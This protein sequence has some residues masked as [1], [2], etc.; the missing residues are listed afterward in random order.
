MNKEEYINQLNAHGITMSMYYE[1][2]KDKN[3]KVRITL[4]EYQIKAQKKFLTIQASPRGQ[5]KINIYNQ[6]VQLYLDK[7]FKVTR[8]YDK[9]GKLL[10]TC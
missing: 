8:I 2:F 9:E 1:C 7:K 3:L 4:Q 5:E 10:L 6:R